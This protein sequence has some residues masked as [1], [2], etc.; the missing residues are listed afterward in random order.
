MVMDTD[1]TKYYYKSGK[2]KII[3]SCFVQGGGY[4]AGRTG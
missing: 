3:F 4:Y 2:K 1:L